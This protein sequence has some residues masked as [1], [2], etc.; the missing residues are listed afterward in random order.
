MVAFALRTEHAKKFC[1]GDASYT[2]PWDTIALHYSEFLILQFS[3]T[4]MP[5][6]PFS[7]VNSDPIIQKLALD[8]PSVRIALR[9]PRKDRVCAHGVG[10]MQKF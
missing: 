6:Y 1:A 8:M 5:P 3:A 10:S 4:N 2:I 9:Q 7:W